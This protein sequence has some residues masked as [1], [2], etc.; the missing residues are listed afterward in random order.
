MSLVAALLFAEIVRV[1]ALV[2]FG[3]A[4]E[5][6]AVVLHEETPNRADAGAAPLTPREA[7][8]GYF[9]AKLARALSPSQHIK[10]QVQQLASKL[11]LGQFFL[12]QSQSQSQQCMRSLVLQ[13]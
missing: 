13:L 6:K 8:L 7:H 4:K 10:S 12:P 9:R 1:V 11:I 3:A 5:G 2:P